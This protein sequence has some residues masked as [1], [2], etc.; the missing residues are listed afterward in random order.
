MSRRFATGLIVGKFAPLHRGHELVIRR[1]LEECGRVFI[2][3][4]SNPE[5]PGCEPARRA[6]WLAQLFPQAERLVLGAENIEALGLGRMLHNDDDSEE[7]HRDFVGRVCEEVFHTRVEAVF[8]SD[9][10]LA[11]FAEHLTRRFRTHQPDH[12]GVQAVV[13]DAEREVIPA[14]GTLLREDVHAHRHL[15]PPVVYA[16]FVERICLLGGE[17]SGKTTLA[18]ALAAEW[19]TTWV[20]E[21]GREY[22][23]ERGGV[24]TFDDLTHIGV[25]Q[26]RREDAAAGAANRFLFCDTSPLTTLFYCQHDFGTAS[27]ELIALANRRYALTLLCAPDIPFDQDGTRQ[28]PEFRDL[29]HAWYLR[30]LGERGVPYT[31]IQGDV[32]RRLAAVRKLLCD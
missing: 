3:S 19:N 29:Q 9:A 1:A 12:P 27:P 15:L 6:K 11:P 21:F 31:L 26:C 32:S 25:E 20:H 16:D 7:A 30:E 18:R 10:Y 28:P 24:L 17:S 4:Y 14:S 22:W 2:L 23:L 8:G 5:H 13:V